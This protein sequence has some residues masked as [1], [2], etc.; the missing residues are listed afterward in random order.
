MSI[1]KDSHSYNVDWME[2]IITLLEYDYARAL[3][4]E[5]PVSRA[6]NRCFKIKY[7]DE[8]QEVP[9]IY[10]I[11]CDRTDK[12]LYYRHDMDRTEGKLQKW[13]ECM[14]NTTVCFGFKS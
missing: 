7:I 8:G 3:M 11:L 4:L 9:L 2:F 1:G 12:K 6:R 5:K 13:V 14:H 10:I